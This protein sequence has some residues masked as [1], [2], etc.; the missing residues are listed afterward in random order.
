MTNILIAGSRRKWWQD[1]EDAAGVVDGIVFS[2][3]PA[4]DVLINGMADGVDQWAREAAER[5]GIRV[6][7]HPANWRA[8]DVF[9]GSAGYK[10]NA[11]MVA[12]A[13]VIYVVW[14]GQSP[15]TR[16]TIEL[17]FKAHKNIEV[18]FP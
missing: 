7:P 12:L 4:H 11:G 3:D 14:D 2:L 9:D 6:D 13:D 15:G 5:R 10:R 1:P 18:L 8:D 17:A 16:S